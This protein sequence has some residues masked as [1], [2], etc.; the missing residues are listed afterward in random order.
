MGCRKYRISR[1]RLHPLWPIVPID[2]AML[3]AIRDDRVPNLFVLHYDPTRWQVQN[4]LLIPRVALTESSIQRRKR[5]SSTARRAGHILYNILL[6][7]IPSVVKVSLVRE[8][9]T[10]SQ[11]LV[12]AVF[13]R[14]EE[15]SSLSVSVRG[16]MLDVLRVVQ[17]LHKREFTNADVYAFASHLQKLHPENN[18]VRPQIRKQLQNLER[19]GFLRHVKDGVWAVR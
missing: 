13:H 10:V 2:N 18:N 15:L 19:A 8:G 6:K 12:R 5:L 3:R 7:N 9:R 14:V 4:L 1:L 11:D 17:A 16:W